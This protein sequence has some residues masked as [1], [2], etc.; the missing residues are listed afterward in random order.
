MTLHRKLLVQ[1]A[2][3]LLAIPLLYAVSIGP[4]LFF[5]YHFESRATATLHRRPPLFGGPTY[6]RV[7]DCYR[8][9]RQAA[10]ATSLGP[11]LFAYL[12]L[13]HVP[14]IRVAG[15]TGTAQSRPRSAPA[16]PA[17]GP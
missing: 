15:K 4:V 9:L 12:R 1:A 14:T 6:W 11:T 10:Y 17:P 5:T 3:V 13:W 7:Y 2:A 16:T 8:P